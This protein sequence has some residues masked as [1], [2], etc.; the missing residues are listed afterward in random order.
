MPRAPELQSPQPQLA[1]S[2]T[3]AELML[4]AKTRKTSAYSSVADFVSPEGWSGL[5]EKN[6]TER[7]PALLESMRA[8]KRSNYTPLMHQPLRAVLRAPSDASA[9]WMFFAQMAHLHADL[10]HESL[11]LWPLEAVDAFNAKTT[12]P[13]PG[14]ITVESALLLARATH[15]TAPESFT[16]TSWSSLLAQSADNWATAVEL[17]SRGPFLAPE[18]GSLSAARRLEAQHDL[19]LRLHLLLNTPKGPFLFS[20]QNDREQQR[21]AAGVRA[22]LADPGFTEKREMRLRPGDP[23]MARSLRIFTNVFGPDARAHRGALALIEH[24][25]LN[26]LSGQSVADALGLPLR[27]KPVNPALNVARTWQEAVASQAPRAFNLSVAAFAFLSGNAEAFD[28][29]NKRV[30]EAN[31]NTPFSRAPRRVINPLWILWHN[32]I[33]ARN[34]PGFTVSHQQAR[35]ERAKS[36]IRLHCLDPQMAERL[37]AQFDEPRP[38]AQPAQMID[39]TGD[40]ARLA[41]DLLIPDMASLLGARSPDRAKAA[42]DGVSACRRLAELGV[43]LAL[44]ASRFKAIFGAQPPAWLLAA[45]DAAAIQQTVSQA[46]ARSPADSPAQGAPRSIR[47]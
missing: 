46:Q 10:F 18:L 20:C 43:D 9:T 3:E 37:V 34:R 7:L 13:F 5:S 36:H 15:A 12:H 40:N 16:W 6:K 35:I 8:A 30:P 19:L 2:S 23:C 26:A 38:D 25:P 45:Q 47:L 29:A 17:L 31:Q 1:F 39:A 32:P 21:V 41:S 44:S 4:R 24:A 22:I 33:E 28:A 14:S 11:R 27:K 42:P